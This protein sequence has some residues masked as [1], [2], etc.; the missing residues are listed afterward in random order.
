MNHKDLLDSVVAN[1]ASTT[2]EETTEVPMEEEINVNPD[3]MIKLT[4]S[5]GEQFLI[6]PNTFDWDTAITK[7]PEMETNHEAMMKM[8]QLILNIKDFNNNDAVDE[9]E[10]LHNIIGQLE[11]YLK[12]FEIL[13]GYDIFDDEIDKDRMDK[14]I[15]KAMLLI[16]D[17]FC[18]S[19][20]MY[21]NISLYSAM[22]L[23]ATDK[24]NIEKGEAISSD[25][26]DEMLYGSNDDTPT[27]FKVVI[28]GTEIVSIVEDDNCAPDEIG[29]ILPGDTDDEDVI[30]VNAKTIFE[31]HAF[32]E[33]LIKEINETGGT[34]NG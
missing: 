29:M 7:I 32:A 14:L 13:P 8:M 18:V 2:S 34:I 4:I 22:K 31:A 16:F 6:D 15:K 28:K 9:K 27:M 12:G 11:E 26:I 20:T 21:R 1:M 17:S 23:M 25:D 5:T 3:E 24:I 30:F 19:Q 33:K 10:A